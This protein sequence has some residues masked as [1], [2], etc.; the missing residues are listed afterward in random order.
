MLKHNDHKYVATMI[1]VGQESSEAAPKFYFHFLLTLSLDEAKSLLTLPVYEIDAEQ[2]PLELLTVT[3][4]MLKKHIRVQ[5][6]Q[7]MFHLVMI[8]LVCAS[9]YVSY[10]R[11]DEN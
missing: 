8:C 1:Q 4:L 11:V 9:V 10:K 5:S 7:Q 6:S 2:M 3:D